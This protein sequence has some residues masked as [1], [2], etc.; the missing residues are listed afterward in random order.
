MSLTDNGLNK[1]NFIKIYH[2]R[3]QSENNTTK[4]L[5]NE[6]KLRIKKKWNKRNCLKKNPDQNY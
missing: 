6:M 2:C 1:M 4:F 3:A 5:A